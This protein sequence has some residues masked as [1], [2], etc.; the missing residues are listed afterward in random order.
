MHTAVGVLVVGDLITDT[1]VQLLQPISLGTDA[2]ATITDAPGGQGANVAHWLVAA[3]VPL[4]RLL[5]SVSQADP[6]DHLLRLRRGG[7][8]P[9]LVRVQGP[10]GRIVVVVDPGGA[11][12]SFLTQRGAA[13]HLSVA[14]ADHVNLDGITWCHISGYLLET[15]EGQECYARLVSRCQNRDIPVSVDPASISLIRSIGQDAYR[16]LIGQVSLLF[17]N[18]AEAKELARCETVNEAAERL[19]EVASMVI[20]TQ[21]AAGATV[22]Q[23]CAAPL[24]AAPTVRSAT[25]PTGAGDAFAAGFIASLLGGGDVAGALQAATHLAGQAVSGVGATTSQM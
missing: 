4:V 12:R 21:G 13:A 8:E 10:P 20:V 25:D 11:E 5:A 15:T 16:Q 22:V 19:L 6:A 18:E 24:S 2:A 1:V 23:R 7:I 3:G 17:P 14:D 9:A